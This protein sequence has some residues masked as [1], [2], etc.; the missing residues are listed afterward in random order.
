MDAFKFRS[1]DQLPFILDIISNQRLYC[2]DLTNLNDPSERMTEDVYR[3]RFKKRAQKVAELTSRVRICSLSLTVYNNLLWAHYASSM[4]GAA[5]EVS[6][7]DPTMEVC[8]NLGITPVITL[9]D[10]G[11]LFTSKSERQ[12]I[13]SIVFRKLSRKLADW[14]YE[15]EIRVLA[16]KDLLEDGMFYR[17]PT[18][19][20]SVTVGTRMSSAA[21]KQIYDLC[22]SK[23]IRVFTAEHYGS[24][25][26]INWVSEERSLQGGIWQDEQGVSHFETHVEFGN[27]PRTA[28]EWKNGSLKTDG[29]WYSCEYR[30][31]SPVR[32]QI[33]SPETAVRSVHGAAVTIRLQDGSIKNGRGGVDGYINLRTLRS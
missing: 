20:Q 19:V 1:E 29:D 14:A 27:G 23:S 7:P 13:D 18:P 26:N 9:I 22:Q 31:D 3:G 4:R 25:M 5:I 28:M 16:L 6:L 2:S 33:V 32:L 8:D 15:Q 10:Y 24:R 21:K 17:L 11:Y 12:P 30:V